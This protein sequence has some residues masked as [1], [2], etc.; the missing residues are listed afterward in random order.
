MDAIF[1]YSMHRFPPVVDTL[2]ENSAW[3]LHNLLHIYLKVKISSWI[4]L[5]ENGSTT[6]TY[7]PYHIIEK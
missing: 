2:Q 5:G 7:M 1:L 6:E 4:Q 3:C